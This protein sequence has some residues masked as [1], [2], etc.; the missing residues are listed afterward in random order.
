MTIAV[1]GLGSMGKRRIRIL[2]EMYPSYSVVGVDARADRRVE[3]RERFGIRTY[4]VLAEIVE[5][6]D[7]AMIC[8]APLSHA[9]LTKTC[10]ERGWHVFTELNLVQDG[11]AENIELSEKVQRALFLSSPF[12]YRDETCF[13]RSRITQD[14]TW[15]YIYH[16]GQYLPSW[17]PWEKYTDFFVGDKRTS[18]CREILSV[19]LPWL[20]A[21]FGAVLDAQIISDTLT[22]LQIGYHDSHMILLRHE[23]GNNG[24]LVVDL[25]SPVAVRKLEAYAEGAYLSWG[26]TPD[27]LRAYNSDSGKLETVTF[28]EETEHLEGYSAFVVENAYKNEI[29]AFFD[30]VLNN[31]KPEYGF[32]EDSSVLALIDRLGV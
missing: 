27:S 11:Y 9:A 8:T 26:G 17:H 19:E 16:I 24:V 12:F 13:I 20:I 3:P 1:V 32:T 23:G 7:C 31:R 18:G 4:S 10:L 2:L 22:T 30:L 15:N 25:V 6:V 28:S 14:R 29:R 5:M 21:S